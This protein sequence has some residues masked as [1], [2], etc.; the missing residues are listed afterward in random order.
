LIS[1]KARHFLV[2]RNYHAILEYNCANSYALSVA[3]LGDRI[4]AGPAPTSAKTTGRK[5]R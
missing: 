2:Y 1:G 5:R 4:A 3:L